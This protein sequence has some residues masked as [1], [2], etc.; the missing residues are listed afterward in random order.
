[1]SVTS[2][3]MSSEKDYWETPQALF[4]ELDAEFGFTLDV[5]STDANAKCPV[6]FTE[7]TDGLSADWGGQR[8]FCN[9]PYGRQVAA[10][11]EKCHRESMKPGT[12]VVAL[13]AA[14]TDTRWFHDHIYGKA[15]V[16]FLRGRV[17]FELGGVPQG[18]APFPSMVVVWR[19]G[20][21]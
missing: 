10:W 3:L 21:R 4:D 16:R 9:P 2:G 14:R 12:L 7:A 17:R 13:L 11:V 19:C 18:S 20:D 15:E 8:V 5:A 1:M 6:H